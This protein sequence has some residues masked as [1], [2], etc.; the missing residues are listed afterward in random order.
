MA[1]T[2]SEDFY[3]QIFKL[4]TFAISGSSVATGATISNI[5]FKE[6]KRD[7]PVKLIAG[8]LAAGGLWSIL[9]HSFN[10]NDC[11]WCDGWTIIGNFYGRIIQGYNVIAVYALY[12]HLLGYL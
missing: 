3:S 8:S 1:I 11:L 7:Y 9:I 10:N 12:C 5:A 4:L 6:Q 2:I